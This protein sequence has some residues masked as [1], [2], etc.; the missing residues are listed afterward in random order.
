MSWSA[1]ANSCALN[2]R[3]SYREGSRVFVQAGA[4]DSFSIALTLAV[5]RHELHHALNISC[6]VVLVVL[7]DDVLRLPGA[8]C[9]LWLYVIGHCLHCTSSTGCLQANVLHVMCCMKCPGVYLVGNVCCPLNCIKCL[10]A[11]PNKRDRTRTERN[12]LCL[13]QRNDTQCCHT[14]CA[15]VLHFRLLFPL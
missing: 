12:M 4:C 14:W 15:N 7:E 3:G 8:A 2:Q 6:I 13:P 11:V 9:Q 5:G 10:Q 1:H